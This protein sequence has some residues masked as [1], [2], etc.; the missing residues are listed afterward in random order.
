MNFWPSDFVI[1]GSILEELLNVF[2]IVFSQSRLK[3]VVEA[4]PDSSG[5][6]ESA[7]LIEKVI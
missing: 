5:R 6:S 2:D 1:H 3:T 7:T 4:H